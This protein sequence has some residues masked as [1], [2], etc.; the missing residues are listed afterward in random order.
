[1]SDPGTT[2]THPVQYEAVY[3]AERSRVTTFFRL[4]LAIPHFILVALWGIPVYVVTVIAWIAIIITGSYP[5][6]SGTSPR[7]TS[8]TRDA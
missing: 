2:T 3:V 7:A 6:A 5:R 8:S 4:I 1:M